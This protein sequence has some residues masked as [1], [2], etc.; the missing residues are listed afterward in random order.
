MKQGQLLLRILTSSLMLI[1]C[2]S[3]TI[4]SAAPGY[5]VSPDYK[6]S[7]GNSDSPIQRVYSSLDWLS[8]QC[9]APK[10]AE[11]FQPVSVPKNLLK[12]D[13]TP[14]DIAELAVARGGFLLPGNVQIDI[15][16]ESTVM[17]DG[18]LRSQTKL[19]LDNLSNGQL[20]SAGGTPGSGTGFQ[21]P[22]TQV[23]QNSLDNQVI[24]SLKVLDI[25]ISNLGQA[26]FGPLH[27]LMNMQLVESLR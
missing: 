19:F 26:Q 12:L 20:S 25:K 22:L 10:D 13:W 14:V 11:K 23:V 9:A 8:N 2:I 15:G 7:S 1:P 4:A 24:E 17:V 3:V 21:L 18:V 27:Q 5:E 6:V 16:F